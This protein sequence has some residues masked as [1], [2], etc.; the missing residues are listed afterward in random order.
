MAET[1]RAKCDLNNTTQHEQARL[2]R[3]CEV[4]I[5][6]ANKYKKEQSLLDFEKKNNRTDPL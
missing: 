4:L 1:R 3:T 6:L 5:M 2:N